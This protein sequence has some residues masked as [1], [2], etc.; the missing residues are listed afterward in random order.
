MQ[1]QRLEQGWHNFKHLREDDVIPPIHDACLIAV[2]LVLICL[3]IT[4]NHSPA[5]FRCC[6]LLT[7]M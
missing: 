4:M 3:D 6:I 5:S 1:F 2:A 7:D